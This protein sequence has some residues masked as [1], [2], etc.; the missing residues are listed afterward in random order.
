MKL[1]RL[2]RYYYLRFIRL[3]GEPYELALGMAFGIFSG[4]M[5]IIPFHTA[6]AVALAFFFKTSKITAA[7]GVW[8]S[9]PFNW[10]ILYYLNYRI[11][12]FILGLSGNDRGF[13]LLM[14]SIRNAGE[15]MTLIT[16]FAGVSGTIMAAFIIGG[17]IMGVIAAVPSYFVFLKIFGLIRTLR[18]GMKELK[19]R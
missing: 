7:I 9:N 2:R 11:G 12:A 3:K 10:Y 19:G 6:V 17:L 4:M 8:I 18:K 5:P 13:S 14:K 1:D 16:H 15:G